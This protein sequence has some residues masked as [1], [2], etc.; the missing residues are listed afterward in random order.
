MTGYKVTYQKNGEQ[1]SVF[2]KTE[3]EAK[4]L[5][6]AALKDAECFNIGVRPA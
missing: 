6:V 5:I 3:H 2:A 1:I 4:K